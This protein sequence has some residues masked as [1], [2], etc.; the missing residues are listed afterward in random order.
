LSI[1]ALGIVARIDAITSVNQAEQL[2][3]LDRSI[4]DFFSVPDAVGQVAVWFRL[5]ERFPEED[6]YGMFWSVLHGIEGLTGYESEL[7]ASLRRRPTHF[8]VLMVNRM[9]NA[10]QSSIGDIEL[11]GL[12]EAVATDDDCLPSVREDARRF[13]DR[14]RARI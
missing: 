8:P 6:A 3:V 13:V 10:G 11:I 2:E 4:Q 14:D 9:L 5:F 12:L 1:D 7:I